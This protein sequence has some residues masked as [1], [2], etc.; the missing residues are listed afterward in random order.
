MQH[1]Y[2]K[3]FPYS[4]VRQEQHEAIEFSIGNILDND[5]KSVII[6]AGTGVGKSAIGLTVARYLDQKLN[7]DED[8]E[9]GAYFVTTQKILQAQ[10]EKDFSSLF[11]KHNLLCNA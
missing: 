7:Y 2:K 1:D 4:E 5:K 3:H 11:C 10:Y 6:E 8:Y 9:K